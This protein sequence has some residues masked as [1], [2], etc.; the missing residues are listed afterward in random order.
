MWC[1]QANSDYQQEIDIV[2]V[3]YLD[4]MVIISEKE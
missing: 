4:Q 3:I 1:G 2:N